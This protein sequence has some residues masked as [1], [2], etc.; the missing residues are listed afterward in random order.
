VV[1][2]A[3]LAVVDLLAL[4]A[5][6]VTAYAAWALPVRHQSPQQYAQL[7]PLLVLFLLAFARA[8]LY[9]GVGLGPVERLRRYSYSTVFVFLL[10][11]AAGFA[12]KL[13]HQYSRVTFGLALLLCLVCLP[14]ARAAL[15]AV[16]G[17][18]RWWREPVAIVGTPDAAASLARRLDDF[19][20]L[21]YRAVAAFHSTDLEVLGA[22][23]ELDA[24]A[25]PLARGGVRV[26]LVRATGPLAPALLER[27]QRHF[28]RVVVTGG[29]G[30]LPV[31]GAVPRDLGGVLGL[32]YTSNLLRPTNRIVKRLTDL[33]LGSLSL[34]VAAPV[35]GLAA[36]VVKVVSRGPAFFVQTR[37]GVGG[38]R[39][40]VPKIRT[41]YLDAEDRL[42]SHLDENPALGEEWHRHFKLRT[43]P[44]LLPGLGAWMRRFSLD[45]LPQLVSVVM[46]DMSLVG[47]R[48]FPDYHLE[49]FPE[50]FRELRQRVRPG[51]TGL[52]Q[53]A[54]R[55]AGSAE[56]QQAMDTYYIRNWSLWLD[57]YILARTAAAVLSGRGAY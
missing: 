27:L 15:L 19:P 16:A 23:A 28:A 25:G 45:E 18:W 30:D 38:R 50:D 42:S 2:V 8:G 35:I 51:I 32:E 44:R 52:W 21:G 24:A 43:D 37:A 3:I 33:M 46:G 9:P 48:P 31:Y 5:C 49:R 13:P 47:P 1:R 29:F 4:G 40:P 36:L 26:V 53:V 54:V 57:A 22:A 11:A 20:G 55:S 12:L 7:A 41:M 34:I 39:I 17:R 10:L 6:S 56:E 14:L